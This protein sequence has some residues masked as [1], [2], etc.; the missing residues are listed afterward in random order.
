MTSLQIGF[1]ELITNKNMVEN[2]LSLKIKNGI[3]N[4]AALIC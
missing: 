2:T 1:L 4:F 3:M